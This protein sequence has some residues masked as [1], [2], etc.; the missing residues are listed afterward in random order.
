MSVSVKQRP[1]ILG[2]GNPL[3]G[4][5]GLGRVVAEQ[6]AQASDLDCE[7]QVIHQLTPELAEQ[8]AAASLVV[9]IDASREGKPGDIHIRQLS[10]SISQPGAIGAH[11]VAPVEIANITI[12]IYGHCPPVI[13]VTMT[14]VD[15]DLG[16]QL[17]LPVT[18]ALFRA[19]TLVR[20]ILLSGR[21]EQG[22]DAFYDVWDRI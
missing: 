2:I 12:T 16:E 17:S 15:F 3:R 10:P 5:D 22:D 7:V 11:H 18:R 4:D 13:V 1:L 21:K 20:R 14:G 19:H 6:L 9:M 8:M